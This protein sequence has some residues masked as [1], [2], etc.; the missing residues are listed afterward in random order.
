MQYYNY[1]S[2]SI[3]NYSILIKYELLQIFLN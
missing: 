2:D 3:F 1:N